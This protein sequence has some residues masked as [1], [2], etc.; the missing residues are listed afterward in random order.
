MSN[1]WF[2]FYSEFANDAK[3]QMMP[4]HMQRRL[5]M[6]FC[7]RNSNALRNGQ[8]TVTD[9]EVAFMLR[10][11]DDEIAQTKALF[12]ERGFINS[13]WE[14]ANWDKRQ[15]RSDADPTRSERQKRYRERNSNALRNG[16]VT[17]LDT[18]TDTD[19]DTEK[20][21]SKSLVAPKPRPSKR[22]PADF[23][24]TAEMLAWASANG[25]LDLHRQTES[26]KDHEFATA[27]TDWQATWRNWMRRSGRD[28]P[29]NKPT[30]KGAAD[31]VM[32]NFRRNQAE[33]G[34]LECQP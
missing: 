29:K 11:N 2:R 33:Q 15:F 1:P 8:D 26:F 34:M 32:E 4:E 5:V 27:K 30:A 18:D 24:I 23:A 19:T 6:L 17:V 9:T 16:Q 28:N 31:R 3:V 14:L 10:V 20:S 22:P 12:I 21:K 7:L 13:A 25:I